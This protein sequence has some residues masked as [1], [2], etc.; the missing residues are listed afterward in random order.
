MFP[1][2][3]TSKHSGSSSSVLASYV[4][5]AAQLLVPGRVT[6]V[7]NIPQDTISPVIEAEGLVGQPDVQQVG[8]II[9]S[10]VCFDIL[11]ELVPYFKCYGLF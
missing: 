8:E 3:F 6:A 5:G 11:E 2:I 9:F 4:T 10:C 7:E 1:A